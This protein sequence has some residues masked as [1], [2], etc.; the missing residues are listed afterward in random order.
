MIITFITLLFTTFIASCFRNN[1]TDY[2]NIVGTFCSITVGV[3]IPG[4]IYIK[5][6]NHYIYHYKNI[7]VII[8]ILVVSLIGLITIYCTIKKV[9]NIRKI[10][11]FNKFLK[12]SKKRKLL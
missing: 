6:N 2:F 5:G 7:L 4:M 8:F 9:Y 12:Y 3:I 11:Y 1:I 10:L